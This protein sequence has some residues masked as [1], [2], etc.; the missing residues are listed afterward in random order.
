MQ[1]KERKVLIVVRS[2]PFGKITS[3]E[4]WRAAVGMYGMDHQPTLLFLG[5]GVYSLMKTIDDK[6][7]RMF[8]STYKGFGGRIC[9]SKRSMDERSI[10]RE[11]I[12]EG[13]DLV[14]A[15]GI[16]ALLSENEVVLTF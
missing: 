5:D 2:K 13:V 10:T 1:F 12:L 11:D 9:A 8:K 6:P 4:G 14:D 15:E 3:F 7:I 16:G